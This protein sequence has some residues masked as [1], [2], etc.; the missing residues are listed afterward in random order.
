MSKL[1]KGQHVHEINVVVN[2]AY[3]PI[4]LSLSHESDR[5]GMSTEAG[6]LTATIKDV[7]QDGFPAAEGLGGIGQIKLPSGTIKVQILHNGWATV[8]AGGCDLEW[9]DGEENWQARISGG[10][11]NGFAV[12]ARGKIEMVK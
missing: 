1:R 5:L 9:I 7:L 2:H 4:R 6:V 8:A 3:N 10:E 12:G 11:I